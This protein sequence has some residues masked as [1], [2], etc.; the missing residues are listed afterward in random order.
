MAAFDGSGLG[1]DAFCRREAISAASLYRWRNL[2]NNDSK[3]GEAAI[4]HRAPAFVELEPL[5]TTAPQR[6]RIELKLD[7]GDGLSLHLV[8]D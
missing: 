7:L 5:N 8:R 6:T 3:S 4:S 2:L 1:V